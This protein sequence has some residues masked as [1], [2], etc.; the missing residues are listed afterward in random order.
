MSNAAATLSCALRCIACG[1]IIAVDIA[2]IALPIHQRIALRETLGETNERIVD[3][4]IAMRMIF[5]DDI[6]DDASAFLK[7]PVGSR[8]SWRIA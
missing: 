8:R 4:L 5:T 2:E 1:G 7:P 3:R 6:A